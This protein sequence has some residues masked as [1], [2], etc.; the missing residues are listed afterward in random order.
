[1]GVPQHKVL[2]AKH[3]GKP[4]NKSPKNNKPTNNLMQNRAYLEA[5]TFLAG[6][7]PGHRGTI[8]DVRK[9]CMSTIRTLLFKLDVRDLHI[10]IPTTY[11]ERLFLSLLSRGTSYNDACQIVAALEDSDN[12]ADLS[13]EIKNASKEGWGEKISEF[14]KG[15][16]K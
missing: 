11:S 12:P 3:M 10:R 9:L 13:T 7:T 6:G 2:K 4:M 5:I 15:S 1:M 16:D 8:E 14:F